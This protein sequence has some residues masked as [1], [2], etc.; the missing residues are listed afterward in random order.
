MRKKF[1]AGLLAL[2]MLLSLVPVTAFAAEGIDEHAELLDAE[3]LETSKI[4]EVMPDGTFDITLEAYA[5]GTVSTTE[6]HMPLD[7][8]LVLDQSGSMADP[9][10][11]KGNITETYTQISKPEWGVIF[12]IPYLK[13]G[14]TYQSTVANEVYH[15]HTDGTYHLINSTVVW[16]DEGWSS[17]AKVAYDC[18]GC[19]FYQEI[20]GLSLLGYYTT[21]PVGTY[22]WASEIYSRQ[23]TSTTTTV[24]RIDALKAAVTTF[25][26]KVEED[27]A[28]NDVNHRIAIVGFASASGYGNNSEIL[29]IEGNNT[30]ISQSESIGVAYNNLTTANYQSALVSCNAEILDKAVEALAA[31][32]ATRTD[33]GMDMAQKILQADL[34]QTPGNLTARKRIVIMFTDGT[35]TS[36]D[37]FDSTVANNTIEYAGN[38]KNPAG[39]IKG[40]VYTIGIFDGADNAS[41][42]AASTNEN[43]FMHATS[44]NYLY[45]TSYTIPT[46][47]DLNKLE[48]YFKADNDTALNNVFT[49]IYGSI[50]T[51]GTT[52]NSEAVMRD[53]IAD[54]FQLPEDFTIGNHIDVLTVDY[55]GN[56]VFGT[57][58]T[59][60]ESAVVTVN[61]DKTVD[62][63]GFDFATEYCVDTNPVKG[64]KLIIKIEGLELD[65]DNYVDGQVYTNGRGSGVYDQD[66]NLVEEFPRPFVMLGKHSYVVDYAKS[67][68]MHADEFNQEDFDHLAIDPT[69]FETPNLSGLDL[70]NGK[71][72]VKDKTTLNY[73]PQTTNWNGYDTFY[74]FGQTHVDVDAVDLWSQVNVIPAN[75]VYYEDTFVS[76]EE[77][78]TEADAVVG[79][80]YGD[81]WKI[82]TDNE[83]TEGTEGTVTETPDGAVMGW[84]ENLAD[85]K[86]FSNG[87]A[88]VSDT[89]GATASFE[90]TGTGVD[91]YSYTD[92]KSGMIIA[93]LYKEGQ[94]V[95]NKTLFMDNLAVSGEYYQIPTL[96]FGPE[97]SITVKNEDGSTTKAPMD[98]GTYTVKLTVVGGKA[99][100]TDENG[101]A[102][103]DENGNLIYSEEATRSTY[104]LDGIRIYNPLGQTVTDDTVVDAYDPTA[105]QIADS[106][107]SVFTEV[108]TILD[109]ADD[110]MVFIDMNDEGKIGAT[111]YGPSEVNN[112]YGPKNE[113]YL[114]AGDSIVFAIDGFDANG[115]YYV[116]LKSLTG[117][118]V[119]AAFTD[120]ASGVAT[121]ITHTTDL[122]YK[123][124]PAADGKVIVRNASES[125]ILSVTKIQAVI[126]GAATFTLRTIASEEAETYAAAFMGF[127]LGEYQ[128][129]V[130]EEPVEPEIPEEPTEPETPEVPDIDIDIENPEPKPDKTPVRP[131][132]HHNL[133]KLVNNLFNQIHGW[134]GR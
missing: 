27:A 116:G 94:T 44:S 53:I 50:A 35:P 78:T 97:T 125:G 25:I 4:V 79:I 41:P 112:T 60:L 123:V 82:V 114:D 28:A 104:Y 5:T 119:K 118:T 61:N 8:V 14:N 30:S 121:D 80:A 9:F 17:T 84:E 76:T 129:P 91:I 126:P 12:F 127:E 107:Q 74:V 71:V 130:V 69:G 85:D 20:S 73:T 124:T 29:S 75:N 6:T 100:E 56:G 58:A 16:T 33:V 45:A 77:G 72:V 108:R 128:Q 19:D 105:D 46:M 93:S 95:A 43:R 120:D 3:G 59:P 117:D 87:A 2:V 96:S 133:K 22:D 106:I 101:V 7:I 122:Y 131:I 83:G 24:D 47:G 21:G 36:S 48:Y 81:N 62:V 26:G 37:R 32:G 1:L 67:F 70:T 13:S 102:M 89:S 40:D 90:F 51:S 113:V 34:A 10:T 66:G 63:K 115:L 65:P 55:M 39:S 38:I 49:T 64:K 68:D 15:K 11:S 57:E 99:V 110:R 18:D 98:Y 103:T 54:S 86:S 52:L 109:A 134:F 42:T 111:D 88:H 23:A 31:N 132:L 92:I